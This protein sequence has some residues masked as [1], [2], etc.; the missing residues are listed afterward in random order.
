MTG[1]PC[2][3]GILGAAVIARKNWQAIRLSG[4]GVVAAVASRDVARSRAFIDECQ[5]HV[6]FVQS[7]DALGSYDELLARP[8]IDAVY[9]P[10]PTG[11]RRDWVIRAAEAG[12]HVLVEKPVGVTVADVEA[13]L[14]ACDR[15]NVQFM[16]GVMFMH[17]QRLEQLRAVLDDGHS[18]GQLR[19]IASQFS[20]N[21]G[22][23]FLHN[24]IRVSSALEPDG[25]LGDLGWYNIRFTL[26]AMRYVMP[27]QVTAR[28]LAEA[29]RP[30]SPAS[31]PLEFSAEMLFPG[32]VSAS[33]YCSFQTE[34]QQWVNL[35]GTK[36][37]VHLRDFV[38]PFFGSEVDFTVT[39]AAFQ[40][41]GCDFNME[42]HTQRYAISEHG[43]SAAD[44]QETRLF[45][46]FADLVLS[47]RRDPHWGAIALK[48]QRVMAACLQSARNGGQPVAL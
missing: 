6:P 10:L 47:G 4:N 13:M 29:A 34:N 2:R 18:V 46:T 22:D 24:N 45:R 16:D 15:H 42:D 28:L 35:S 8:D 37:F 25:C 1:R 38:L 48:T 12:K 40:A 5:S 33:F 39:N 20:F 21:A 19:R 7:P 9:I 32:G 17:S 27:T 44:A 43:S 14:A 30:D 23:D 26:W 41:T 11:V 3:W 31:V 36:G